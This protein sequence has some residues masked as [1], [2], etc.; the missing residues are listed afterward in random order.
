MLGRPDPLL[1]L[2]EGVA[3]PDYMLYGIVQCLPMKSPTIYRRNLRREKIDRLVSVHT[4]KTFGENISNE[5][6]SGKEIAGLLKKRKMM[7][8]RKS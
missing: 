1:L 7:M 4:S 2:R 3:K 8:T 5:A 6:C